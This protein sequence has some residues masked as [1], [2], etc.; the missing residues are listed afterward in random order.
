MTG[1]LLRLD[2]TLDEAEILE[3][4]LDAYRREIIANLLGEPTLVQTHAINT[5]TTIG[6]AL[7]ASLE[8]HRAVKQT[9]RRKTRAA[10]RP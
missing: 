5:A 7:R 9:K 2:V 6:Q 8:K 10:L 3:E 4:A 1:P